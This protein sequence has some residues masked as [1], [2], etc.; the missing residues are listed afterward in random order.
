MPILTY[1]KT[2]DCCTQRPFILAKLVR[3]GDIWFLG[4]QMNDNRKQLW[5]VIW[6]GWHNRDKYQKSLADGDSSSSLIY[7]IMNGH[8]SFLI[9]KFVIIGSCNGNL[10]YS[11]CFWVL[12]TQFGRYCGCVQLFFLRIFISDVEKYMDMIEK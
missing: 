1:W 2:A 6:T 9:Y 12:T 5:D 4:Y 10:G 8:F 11:S 7:Q 3:H